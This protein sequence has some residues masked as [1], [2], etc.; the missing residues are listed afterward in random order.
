MQACD[1]TRSQDAPGSRVFAADRQMPRSQGIGECSLSHLLC[2][3]LNSH[4]TA[5][6]LT[7]TA[8]LRS[9]PVGCAA[10]VLLQSRASAAHGFCAKVSGAPPKPCV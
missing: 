4:V 1:Y 5:A 8:S 6:A 7:G 3:G 9:V 10:N 2:S